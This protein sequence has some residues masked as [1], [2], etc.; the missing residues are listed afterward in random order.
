MK[1]S[2]D[3]IERLAWDMVRS[4]TA[5]DHGRLAEAIQK[6][7]DRRL[8]PPSAPNEMHRSFTRVD[9]GPV[10]QPGAHR[11]LW[12]LMRAGVIQPG[13]SSTGPSLSYS[14]T[15]LVKG[16][17]TDPLPADPRFL[18][19]LVQEGLDEIGQHYIREAVRCLNA[20]AFT[21]AV[22]MIGVASEHVATSLIEAYAASSFAAPTL[23]AKLAKTWQ[24]KALWDEFE[25]DFAPKE[26]QILKDANVSDGSSKFLAAIIEAIRLDR[27]DAGH[28]SGE[29]FE[30]D[31]VQAHLL[32]FR[33]SLGKC[34]ELTVYLQRK[35]A[36]SPPTP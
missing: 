27:N 12:T 33:T 5:P 20:E 17:A 6:E 21:A 4:G 19:R 8:N 15:T 24:I 1:L 31:E 35:A 7:V 23:R 14:S 30:A 2:D 36:P 10:N 26:K 22:A 25:K 29:T 11:V 28:P 18:D 9:A 3:E 13:T 16:P 32:F 34:R